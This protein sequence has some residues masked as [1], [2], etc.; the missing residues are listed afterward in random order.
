M[1]DEDNTGVRQ[2][3]RARAR[4]ISAVTIVG[5]TGKRSMPDASSG[6]T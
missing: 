4:A 6:I 1:N 5:G 2:L 3:E